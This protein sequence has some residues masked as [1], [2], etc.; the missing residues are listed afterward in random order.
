VPLVDNDKGST[1]TLSEYSFVVKVDSLVELINVH[2]QGFWVS[3]TPSPFLLGGW[4]IIFIKYLYTPFLAYRSS[5]SSVS[6]S[7]T[8][9]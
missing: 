6:L 2:T 9:V 4:I 1:I 8:H 7:D 3:D 5:S